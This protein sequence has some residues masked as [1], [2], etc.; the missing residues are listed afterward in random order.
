MKAMKASLIAPPTILSV[1]Q[2][3]LDFNRQAASP[4]G[5]SDYKCY[6]WRSDYAE[7]AAEA[8]AR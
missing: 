4:G 8:R 6:R 3:I 1:D 5:I 2:R 7:R